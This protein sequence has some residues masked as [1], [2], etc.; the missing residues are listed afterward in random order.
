MVRFQGYETVG[1][2]NV[3]KI[4]QKFLDWLRSREISNTLVG[5]LR[6]QRGSED[7]GLRT[8]GMHN[9]STFDVD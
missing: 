2:K 6:T 4:L 9:P 1:R 5:W 3:W 8:V 7:D